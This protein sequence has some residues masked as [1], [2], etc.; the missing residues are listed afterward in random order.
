MKRAAFS[1]ALLLLALG[2]PCAADT[3]VVIVNAASGIEKLDHDQ[4]VNIYMGRYK[5]LPSGISALPFDEPT[6]KAGFYRGLVGKEPEEIN[7]YWARLYFSGQGSP[8]R[9]LESAAEVIDAVVQNKGAIGYIAKQKL[10]P[11]VKVVHEIV[12]PPASR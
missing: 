7:S 11:R 3:L 5:R 1:I 10:D 4:V 6:L 8:P 9:Q 12:V 2:G